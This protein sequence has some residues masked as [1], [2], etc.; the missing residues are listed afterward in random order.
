MKAKARANANIALIKYW[1]KSNEELALPTN[2]SLSLTLDQFYTETEVEFIEDLAE[3]SFYLDNKE[4]K[5]TLKKVSKFLDLFREAKNVNYR[6]IVKS[7]NYVPTAAG[8]ASSASAF[9][10]L[11]AAANEALNLGLSK[12]ELSTFVRKGSG[13][14][15]RSVYGGLVQWEKGYDD[16]SSFAIEI[17][18]ADW[19]IGMIAVIVNSEEKE[20]SSREGMKHTIETSP[21]YKEWPIEAEKDLILIKEAI[22]DRDFERMGAIAENNA[23]KMHATMMSANPSIIYFEPDSIRAINIVKELRKS[24]ISAYFTMDAGP[25]VKIICRLSDSQK[26]KE[27]LLKDFKEENIIISKPGKGIEII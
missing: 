2:S 25:N 18:D 22:K 20:I 13:S 14:A 19:D 5:V 26:I 11:G 16:K 10:A 3:D 9:A 7:V 8:L 12:E 24:G 17:D 23:L 15:T 6:A 1:G 4:D 27:Y 21:F